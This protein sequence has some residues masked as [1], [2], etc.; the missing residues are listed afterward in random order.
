MQVDEKK[1]F[2][3][4]P[5]ADAWHFFSFEKR[6]AD[7]KTKFQKVDI[8]KSKQF[9][10][11]LFLDGDIQSSQY[12]EHVYHE[13]LVQPAMLQHPNPKKVLILG[14]GEG[15]TLREVLKHKSVEKAV[16]I[17]IDEELVKICKEHLPE[18]HQESFDDKRAEILFMDAFKYLKETEEK[19]DVI[20]EDLLSPDLEASEALFRKELFTGIKN[21]L[22]KDGIAVFQS[23]RTDIVSDT[24]VYYKKFFDLVSGCFRHAK[25]FHAFI[26][27]FFFTW[28]YIMASGSALQVTPEEIDRRIKERNLKLE[29]YNSTTEKIM[30]FFPEWREIS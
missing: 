15:A 9:G 2:S 24:G 25:K 4:F 20:I 22:A 19:F 29:F 11:I 1:W 30:S 14:G 26:P 5:M 13:C 16:M 6:I 8:I 23:G 21:A 17:D 18:W 27:S 7:K 28:G 12:D 3:M 10:K